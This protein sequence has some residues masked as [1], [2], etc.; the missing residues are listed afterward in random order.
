M[1]TSRVQRA[2]MARTM[3]A[4]E[5][6]N[7]VV[8]ALS[9]EFDTKVLVENISKNEIL[10]VMNNYEVLTS[11]EYINGLSKPYGIDKFIL[12]SFEKQGFNFD[13]NKSQYIQCCFGVFN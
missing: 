8:K 7:V 3:N 5:Y 2:A 13:I 9:M 1:N 4:E 11:M 12:Q 6:L 10:I